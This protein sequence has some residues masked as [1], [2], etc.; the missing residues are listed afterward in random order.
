MV[1]VS[2]AVQWWEE[3]QL[4]ILVLASLVIQYILI[5]SSA[6]RK[7][8]I[9]SWFRP[10]IW[11]AYLGSDAIAI[12]AL[13]TLFNRHR[14]PHDDGD[15]HGDSNSILEV[16]WAPILLIH[17]GGQ[18]GITAYNIEDNELWT[19]HIFTAVTQVTVAVYIFCKSWPGGNDR[20]LLVAAILLFIPGILKCIEKPLALR[21][22]SINSLVSSGEPIQR[23]IHTH[24][25]K[26]DPLEDFIDKATS[27][28]GANEYLLTSATPVD[29]TPYKL[30]VDLASP[31]V[32]DRIRML[33][34]FST[35]DGNHAYCKLQHWLSN[36]FLILYTKEKVFSISFLKQIDLSSSSTSRN[37]FKLTASLAVNSG[38]V[39]RALAL[40]LPFIAL[41]IF[42]HSNRE[43]YSQ[44]DVKVTYTLLCCTAA[45]E[46]PAMVVRI[47]SRDTEERRQ[48]SSDVVSTDEKPDFDDK[49]S[50]YSLI[51]LLVRNSEH[52]KMMRI[53]GVLGCTD[54]LQQH[55]HMKSC[56]SSFSI[57]KVVLKYVK[58]GWEHHIRDVSSYRKFNDNRGQF[59]LGHEGC[60]EE[61]GWSLEGAFDE[62]V[63][64]WH[65]AT[66]FCYYDMGVSRSHHDYYYRCTQ[67][68]CPDAY[69][70]PAWCGGSD[71]CE[72][73]VQCRE[74]SNYMMYLLF[75]NPE[76]LMP[77]TR[78]NLFTAAY[79][80]LK[81]IVAKTDGIIFEGY[82]EIGLT[83]MII[84]AVDCGGPPPLGCTKQEQGG[85]VCDAWSIAKVLSNLPEEKMWDVIEGVWVEMLCFSAARC[86]G[87]LHA[88]GLATGVEYLTY[89]WLLLY[90]MGMETLA[91]KLQRADHHHH[92]NG[93]EQGDGPSSSH[94]CRASTAQEDA[95]GPSRSTGDAT[96]EEHAKGQS[97]ACYHDSDGIVE[98]IV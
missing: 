88:K 12:Y 16:L 8:P 52:S 54:F 14:K 57:T 17:L 96:E 5:V 60:Y 86:R 53:V 1:G 58:G 10:V 79:D 63:L 71:H 18:D 38:L 97:A 89:V 92:H 72:K 23:S 42:H 9:R 94:G 65:L 74:M 76:M 50:Q 3:S 39:L 67:G 30:F 84:A 2:G 35:L 22:A 15:G 80:E 68:S 20:N 21:R 59:T 64:L 62:S 4:R 31:S 56:S 34:S 45:L 29:F 77:G 24:K 70:C 33:L 36:T 27:P 49:V 13:A 6:A 46:F 95:P 87:Y 19:R 44:D 55:W 26:F 28:I 37:I 40:Y 78:R 47:I 90:Y 51:G 41:V 75:V 98:E 93:G 7:L 82:E 81:D 25:L 69:S 11:L 61:L 48:R 85:I 91:A 32:D 83:Q 66:D 43:V 73:A